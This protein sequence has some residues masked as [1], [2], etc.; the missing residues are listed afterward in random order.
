MNISLLHVSQ[1]GDQESVCYVRA[2]S[3]LCTSLLH[4]NTGDNQ[5]KIK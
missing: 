1:Q 3:E 5:H 2:A 4:I